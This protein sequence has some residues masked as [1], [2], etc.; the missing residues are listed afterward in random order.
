MLIFPF[1]LYHRKIP[2]LEVGCTTHGLTIMAPVHIG[3]LDW[4]ISMKFI[5][6]QGF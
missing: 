1:F 4:N 5:N 3:P 2:G 6:H